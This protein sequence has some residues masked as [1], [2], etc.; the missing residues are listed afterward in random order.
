VNESKIKAVVDTQLFLRAAINLNSLPAKIIFE[1]RHQYELIASEAII[2]EVKDVLYRPKIRAKFPHLT[3]AIADRVL[4]RLS[5]VSIVN[6]TDT[7][8]ISRDPKDDIFL[9]CAKASNAQYIVS[10]DKDL[11]VLNPYEGIQIINALDFSR[12]LQNLPPDNE[13]LE[14]G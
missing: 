2:S 3:N 1:L 14:D 8:S 11:L 10:E 7:E 12:V 9:A 5:T 6:P 13:R 4:E